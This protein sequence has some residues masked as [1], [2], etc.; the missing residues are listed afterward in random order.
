MIFIADLH[1]HSHYSRATSKQLVPEYIDYWARIKGITLVGTGDFTH[2]AWVAELKEKLTPAEPGLFKLKPEYK[3]KTAPQLPSP[4][5]SEM[6]FILSSEISNIYKK[7]AKVRKIHNVIL[8]PDFATVDRIQ[9]A[10]TKIG[11]NIT[12]DGRP[13]LGLAAKDLL[14][15]VLNAS[16]DIFFIPAHIWTPWF[17]ALGHKSGFDSLEEC[18]EDLT[19]HIHAAE[20]GLSSDIPMNYLCSFLD[21]FN[22]VSNSDAHSPE[23]LGRNANIFNTELSYAAVCNALRTGD[24]EKFSGTIDLFPQEGK[25]HYDGHR[26]CGLKW[27]PLETLQHDSICPH[28]GKKVVIGVLNRVVQLSD[29][30]TPEE[31]PRQLPYRYVIP[32]KEVLSEI[33]GVGPNSKTVA[34]EY[35]QII[36]ILGAELDILLTRSIPDIRKKYN[37]ILAEAIDRMRQR[38][39]LIEEGFDGQYGTIQVFRPGEVKELSAGNSLFA[40]DIHET[41]PPYKSEH[42]FNFS[43]AEYQRLKRQ[44][45]S[46]PTADNAEPVKSSRHLALNSEQLQAVEHAEGPALVIAGPGTGKTHTLTYR[47]RY[48][49]DHQ[50]V[51]PEHILGVTFTNKAAQE[52]QSRLQTLF[53]AD[54]CK[55]QPVITTFHR[56]GLLILRENL[57][58]SNRTQGFTILAETDKKQILRTELSVPGKELKKTSAK[59]TAY[60]QNVKSAD[61]ITDTDFCHVFKTYQNLNAQAN[62]YDL[63][64]LIY[65]PVKLL[66]KSSELRQKYQQQFQYILIDEYQDIN[67]AQYRLIQL[68]LPGKNAN[69]YAIGDPNQAIYGFRGADVQYIRQFKKDYPQAKIY[70]LRQSYRCSQEI[71]NT[72]SRLIQPQAQTQSFL[73]GLQEGIKIRIAPQK[74]DRSEAEFVARTI[75]KYMGGIRFFSI[76]SE[77]TSGYE[78]VTE[79]QL[80]DFAVLARLNQQLDPLVKAFRDHG[81][82]YQRVGNIPFYQRPPFCHLIDLLRLIQAPNSLLVTHRLQRHLKISDQAIYDLSQQLHGQAINHMLKNLISKYFPDLTKNRATDWQ[83]LQNMALQYG[84]NLSE[85]IRN[86]QMTSGLDTYQDQAESVP[87]MTL[88]AAKGLE[89]KYVFIVGCED[90]L[91][92]YQLYETQVTDVAEERRLL[93]VGLTRAKKY[94]YLTHAKQRFINGK[95]YRLQR[96]PF[97]DDIITELQEVRPEQYKIKTDQDTRQLNLF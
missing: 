67:A 41:T 37:F 60:K 49:I 91:L 24:P 25:Y 6:R 93:Y 52:M 51:N 90:R 1:I 29:R 73:E 86:L 62:Q 47:I 76:D 79:N 84:E 38:K 53:V 8:A 4:A 58:L 96:S 61:D 20:T 85:F 11:G 97:L 77:V 57:T 63:D 36:N 14:E 43:I 15:L 87:L 48:L 81:I 69:L 2:P 92:P 35:K 75:E 31:R 65:I 83:R 42:I 10:L 44:K 34:R 7:G 28:C 16:Q 78:D 19:P 22:M 82:P 26:K 23:K 9:A 68:L 71:L 13:I 32:L 33:N 95:Q 39:V 64:D 21:R 94:L 66:E 72:S 27:N 46:S 54:E 59:I 70:N 80:S 12:S 18:F 74:T 45:R 30:D 89:F 17:S 5:L 3:I 55:S 40:Y 56:L 88:H 50:G